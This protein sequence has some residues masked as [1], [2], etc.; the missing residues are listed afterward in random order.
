MFGEVTVSNLGKDTFILTELIC[1][2]DSD[3]N[4]HSRENLDG[5]CIL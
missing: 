1:P 2:L 3:F 5:V 4:I